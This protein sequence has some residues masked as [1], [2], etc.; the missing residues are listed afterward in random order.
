MAEVLATDAG[1][2]SDET[3][4]ANE[5]A[6]VGA[7]VATVLLPTA[8]DDVAASVLEVTAVPLPQAANK[9]TAGKASALPSPRRSNRRLLH[10]KRSAMEAS[11]TR[12]ATRVDTETP[13]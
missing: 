9:P 3:L 6:V 2:V 13:S 11:F 7:P 5:E 8:W 12:G 1:F 4:V 10:A